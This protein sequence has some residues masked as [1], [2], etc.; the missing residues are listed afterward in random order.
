MVAIVQV[1]PAEPVVGAYPGDP[2]PLAATTSAAANGPWACSKPW[3]T[4]VDLPAAAPIPAR[5]VVR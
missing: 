1:G 2:Y 5:H 4:A 3:Q